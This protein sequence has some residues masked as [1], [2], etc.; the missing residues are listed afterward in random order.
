M[1]AVNAFFPPGTVR[2]LPVRQGR[3]LS[4]CTVVKKGAA[5]M[6]SQFGFAPLPEP[7][8]PVIPDFPGEFGPAGG[9]DVFFFFFPS[10][11]GAKRQAV[12]VHGLGGSSTNWTDL[13]YALA[14]V[15][16]GV[17]LDLPGFG[18][19]EPPDNGDY[20]QAE[21]ARLVT[22]FVQR[23]ATMPV[24]LFGNSLGGAVATRVAA[25]R[26]DL[27]A[28]VTLISPALPDARPRLSIAPVVALAAPGVHNLS[29][30]AMR[31]TPT[32]AVDH[33]LGLC[34]ADP[35]T[36]DP[37]R[38]EAEIAQ[39]RRL[40]DRPNSGAPLRHSALGL[41]KSFLPNTADYSWTFASK[42]HTPTLVVFG[43]RDKLV[44]P[45]LASKAAQVFP[46][47]RVVVLPT[48]HVAQM[49]H[50]HLVLDLLAQLWGE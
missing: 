16:H 49:E 40:M 38:R 34:F 4:D 37:S 27:V 19:S 41:A 10:L 28:S 26:P 12:F 23:N 44:N 20:S 39:V 3:A 11:P 7:G 35:S 24:D 17:A 42:I 48:G 21:F 15:A 47:A 46:N 6:V 30:F 8:Q 18:R 14:P 29:G 1:A 33:M 2:W 22:D 13:M 25:T 32:R 9:R 5:G 36:V 45:R 50:P 31:A 43:A